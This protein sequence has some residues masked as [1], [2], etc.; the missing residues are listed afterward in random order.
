MKDFAILYFWYESLVLKII[1][2]FLFVVLFYFAVN[3]ILNKVYPD[4]FVI[5]FFLFLFLEIFMHF[6]VARLLPKLK[7]VSNT[8]DSVD[9][10]TVESLGI[11]ETS[12][13][14]KN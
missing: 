8:G 1:R 2:I 7:V 3:G 9:S 6:K 5:P 13:K 4:F 10:F 11:L 12:L 14:T